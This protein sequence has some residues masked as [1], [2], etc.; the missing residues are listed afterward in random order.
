VSILLRDRRP[1]AAGD[2]LRVA[3]D[4]EGVHLFDAGSGLRLPLAAAT[5]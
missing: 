5:A 4:P 1:I 3:L 2:R